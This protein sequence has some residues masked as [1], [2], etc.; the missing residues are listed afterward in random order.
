MFIKLKK[1]LPFLCLIIPSL[2]YANPQS[3]KVQEYLNQLDE[4]IEF[5][6][7]Y[8]KASKSYRKKREYTLQEQKDYTCNL[9]LLYSDLI[10]FQSQ[11]LQLEMYSEVALLHKPISKGL[12]HNIIFK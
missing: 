8:V 7:T 6:S 10:K 12:F 5:I 4:K 1:N 9:K 3:G 11:H 2:V